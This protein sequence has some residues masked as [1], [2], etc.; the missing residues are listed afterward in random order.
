VPWAAAGKPVALSDLARK[1]HDALAEHERT[2]EEL[3]LL[4]WEMRQAQVYYQ[5][6][7]QQVACAQ[8]DNGRKCKVY[9]DVI[10]LWELGRQRLV[11]QDGGSEGQW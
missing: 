8:A 9:A 5:Y 3:H 11:V 6:I 2:L 1:Y 4:Q 7:L 10:D